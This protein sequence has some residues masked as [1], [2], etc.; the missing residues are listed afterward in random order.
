MLASREAI[1]QAA[2]L[3]V[4]STGCQQADALGILRERA[5]AEH[6]ND[7][8]MAARLLTGATDDDPPDD[9]TPVW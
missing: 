2:G 1:N 8:D 7:R 6:I 5:V 3:L 4:S 9:A